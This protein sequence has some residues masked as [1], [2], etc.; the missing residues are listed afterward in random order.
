MARK[1]EIVGAPGFVDR[2]PAT[3]IPGLERVN[4]FGDRGD[5]TVVSTAAGELLVVPS[6][7]VHDAA[8]GEQER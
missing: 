7:T 5:L 3:V 4:G 8:E 6:S 1:V 2:F